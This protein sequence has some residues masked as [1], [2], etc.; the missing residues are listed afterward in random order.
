M[1]HSTLRL[2]IFWYQ[3]AK[4]A[5]APWR[6]ASYGRG[7]VQAADSTEPRASASGQTLYA[8]FCKLVL[9]ELLITRLHSG[10]RRFR[11]RRPDLLVQYFHFNGSAIAGFLDCGANPAQLDDAVA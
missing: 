9:G 5:S 10:E 2:A 4:S 11:R 3:V 1:S 6:F 7:S 8:N